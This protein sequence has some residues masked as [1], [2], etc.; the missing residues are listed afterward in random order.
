MRQAVEKSSNGILSDILKCLGDNRKHMRVPYVA[1]ALVD[2]KLGA[3]GRN[4]LFDWLSRQ[5]SGLSSF[6]E[7]AQLLKPSLF[8]NGSMFWL[9]NLVLTCLSLSNQFWCIVYLDINL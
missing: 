7:A 9:L 6:A 8:F 1:I 4:D 3:E 5:L 2:S